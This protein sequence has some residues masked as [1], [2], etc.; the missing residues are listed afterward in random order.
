MEGRAMEMNYRTEIKGAIFG[1]I[2]KYVPALLA[3]SP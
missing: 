1:I 2:Q 3:G